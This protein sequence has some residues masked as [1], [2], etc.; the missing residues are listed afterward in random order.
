MSEPSSAALWVNGLRKAFDRPVVDAFDLVV[1]RGEV[2]AL[3]G[4]NG[5]GKTTTLRIIAGLIAADGGTV[6]VC[7]VSIAANPLEAR[8]RMAWLP[9][10]PMIY[11]KLTPIE[12]LAFMAGLWQVPAATARPRGEELL[13]WLDLW[14][15]RHDRC[16]T[17]SRGMRQKV[18]LAGALIHEPQLLLLDEPLT[19]LDVAAVRQVK[20]FLRRYV[21][22]GGAVLLTTHILDVAER[23]SD[24]IG[25]MQAGSL[26]TQGTLAELRAGSGTGR[27]SLEDL[28]VDL[29]NRASA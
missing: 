10:E 23:I 28:F 2:Y 20:D 9:D 12:Y 24:R 8:R 6:E 25:I 13:T 18:A 22:E 16:E 3:L 26:L 17:F 15:R 14:T 27:E 29:T 7:G 11:D 5:V 21:Q 1:R 19:G 4:H